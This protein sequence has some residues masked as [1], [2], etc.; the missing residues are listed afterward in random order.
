MVR[1]FLSAAPGMLGA[2]LVAAEDELAS[3]TV[4]DTRLGKDPRIT[5]V[6]EVLDDQRF[7]PTDP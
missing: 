2:K 5:A 7:F 6:S 4:I 1:Q 3:K